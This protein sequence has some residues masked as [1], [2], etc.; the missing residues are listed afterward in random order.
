MGKKEKK[1]EKA[2][3]IPEN[4]DPESNGKRSKKKKRRNTEE[5]EQQ[6]NDD[7]P[8]IAEIPTVTIALPGS[9]VDNTQSL[10]LATRV[11]HSS[12]LERLPFYSKLC[13]IYFIFGLYLLLMEAT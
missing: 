7:V 10:E 6:Q 4:G 12:L 11:I 3:T 1:R 9:I 2:E 13:Y 5:A 8:S